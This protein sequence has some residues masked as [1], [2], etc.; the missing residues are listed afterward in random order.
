MDLQNGFWKSILAYMTECLQG[1]VTL[2]RGGPEDESASYSVE[3]ALVVKGFRLLNKLQP[4]MMDPYVR[5][6]LLPFVSNARKF[7]V[8]QQQQQQ[9]QQC[10]RRN[11]RRQSSADKMLVRECERL[12][13]S[14]S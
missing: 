12:L 10:K 13:R 2:P 9:Q 6:S 5:H 7:G 4:E 11:H 1:L 3:A 8:E 14:L